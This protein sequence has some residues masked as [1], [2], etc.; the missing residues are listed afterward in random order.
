MTSSYNIEMNFLPFAGPVPLF[1]VYR[2]NREDNSP[3]PSAETFA[4]SLPTSATD[5]VYRKFWIRFSEADGFQKYL[6]NPAD[7]PHLTKRSMCEA[8]KQACLRHLDPTEYFIPNGSFGEEVRFNFERYPE[9]VEQLVV[10]PYFLKAKKAYGWLVDFH[11]SC[12]QDSVNFRRVQ[13]L[14]LSLDSAFKRNLDCYA[15]R[16]NKIK[17]FLKE[18]RRVLDDIIFLG[19]SQPVPLSNS[20]CELPATVL[21]PKTYVFANGAAGKSQIS[22][23]RQHGPLEA[24]KPPTLL[25]MFREC[26]RQAARNLAQAIKGKSQNRNFNFPGF[27]QLFKTPLKIDSNPI[28]LADFSK[29]SFEQAV[30]NVKDRNQEEQFIPVL[31]IPDG[32]DEV[33]LQHKAVFAHAGIPTQVC[34]IGL[35][36]D[37]YALKWAIA[38]ISLQI[39]CKAGGQP[40]KVRPTLEKTLIIGIGQSHKVNTVNGKR[41]VEKYFAF[42]VLT[43]NSG[44][45]QQIQVLGDSADENEYLTELNKNLKQLL[46][47]RPDDYT[48]VV[49]HVSFKLKVKEMVTIENTVKHATKTSSDT[50]KFAVVKVNHKSRFFGWNRGVNSLVP[51]EGS[52]VRL[53]G[54]EYVV[55]F[56]GILQNNPTVSKAYPGP[57][58]VSFLRMSDEH[59]SDDLLLQ[60][61]L[62]LSGA[63]W[64]G[65]NAKSAPVSLYYC[66]L[67]ADLVHDFHSQNLP[68]PKIHELSPWFL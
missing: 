10:R 13:Q 60:D 16:F 6:C 28:V 32:E 22:G 7:N 18:R 8:L 51:L 41:R 63:N 58:H 5:L 66:Q 11:F 15:D 40:W 56:E 38:N 1:E 57:T 12:N 67:I 54:S 65:F 52:A 30:S 21:Q 2:R 4:F 64:R 45:F 53:G 44:L 26:D 27:E 9:G 48:Q 14:S 55:W 42:S 25:F 20:F 24:S 49:L 37:V 50:C 62:N 59:I 43:D 34:R 29:T 36:T 31:I 33:Y 61:L 47:R 23:L 19:S 46:E 35:I 68:T 17:S 39:F 3:K